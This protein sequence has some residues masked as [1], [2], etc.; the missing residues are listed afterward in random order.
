M[1]NLYSGNVNLPLTPFIFDKIYQVGEA[2]DVN[3]G[4]FVN[5]YVLVKN[6]TQDTRSEVYQ[7]I[8][9]NGEVKYIRIAKF[10]LD[11]PPLYWK[12]FS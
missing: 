8:M 1:N 4:V 10:Y 2:L 5:R 9:E 11:P 3:D 12:T 7:K 6:D